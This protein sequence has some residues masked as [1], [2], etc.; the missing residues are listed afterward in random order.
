MRAVTGP[1]QLLLQSS[2][3]SSKVRLAI[4]PIRVVYS[5]QVSIVPS[6]LDEVGEIKYDNGS[7]TLADVRPGMTLWVGSTAG[8]NDLG[9][10]RI[11]KTPTADTFY[12]GEHSDIAWEVDQHLTVIEDYDLWAK[13]V[14]ISGSNILMDFD[15]DYDDQHTDFLP[16][17]VLGSHRVAKLTGA[18][19]DVILGPD[20]GEASYVF[21]STITGYSWSVPGSTGLT[22]S[23]T[24]TPTATFDEAGWYPC[25][26]TVTAANGKSKTGMR[27]VYIWDDDNEPLEVAEISSL[28]EDVQ[29]GG[30]TCQLSF[31]AGFGSDIPERSLAII[32]TESSYDHELQDIG[33]VTHAENILF[34]GRF[35][36]E[37]INRSSGIGKVSVELKS[38]QHW[39]SQ[40]PTYP[41]G[42]E[43]AKNTP[44][45]W[46]SLT[47]LTVDRGL[48]H[49]LEWRSTATEIMDVFLT[50]D[51]RY[52]PEV[53][54]YA[55]NLWEM[56]TQFITQ[57]I[58][59]HIGIDFFGR[60]FAEIDPQIRAD[61][62]DLVEVMTL[63]D[64]DLRDDVSLDKQVHGETSLVDL[65]GMAID[66]F[67]GSPSAFFSLSPGH[68]F[69]TFGQV[70][71]LDRLLLSSQAQCNQI[72]GLYLGWKNSKYRLRV[73]LLAHN[74]MISV[75]PAQYINYT[76]EESDSIREMTFTSRFIPRTRTLSFDN[77]TGIF[78][79]ELELEAETFAE[80]AVA[81][82][83]P[84]GEDISIP[85]LEPLP[86]IPIG[87]PT[88][89][90]DISGSDAPPVV[91]MLDAE[92]G[93]LRTENF[94][95]DANDVVWQFWNTGI[96]SADLPYLR[97]TSLIE[98]STMRSI[99][100]ITP[101]GAC[102]LGVRDKTFRR[103][104]DIIYRA[105]AIGAVWE[106]VLDV[107]WIEE[108]EGANGGF[109]GFGYN[110]N[111]AEEVAFIAA[112]DVG[113]G[114]SP[115]HFYYG[116]P[117]GWI[118]G[119]V[120]PSVQNFYGNITF[121][122]GQ[123]VW[124]MPR[125][126]TRGYYYLFGSDGSYIN[127]YEHSLD[128]GT[129]EHVRAGTSPVI[130]IPA[131]NG[132]GL[133]SDDNGVTDSA[134]DLTSPDILGNNLA[135]SPDGYMMG[136]YNTTAH[137]GRSSDFG[138]TWGAN[139]NLNPGGRYAWKWCGGAT[140]QG[141]WIAARA[142]IW[143]SPDWGGTWEDKDGNMPYLIPLSPTIVKI[144]VPGYH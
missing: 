101:N 10:L 73:T 46:T 33:Q 122:G 105:P 6:S 78:K 26:C 35:S 131:A 132:D 134:I 118:Q 20:T 140:S 109:L 133:F 42:V 12:L 71:I 96:A 25:Y 66:E 58:L 120:P 52:S 113:S 45:E 68:V 60:F 115:R 28:S 128:T 65:S 112:A 91:L 138:F 110:P 143:Y 142:N 2:Y 3:Q 57:Q 74:F 16:V 27:W 72:A 22:G 70:E 29:S 40:L 13:H 137:K 50:N 5:A 44:S 38:H 30:G 77:Q 127:R 11:R 102:Y 49:L 106:K 48:W 67:G 90:G 125:S 139:A 47:K 24:A 103:W 92:K 54:G 85:P 36:H 119:G 87:Y 99:F 82:V 37:V 116:N 129:R 4:L 98:N 89:P 126:G 117:S 23:T 111:K 94:N 83:P 144:L 9:R 135:I 86:S 81:Y 59:G 114:V 69:K 63:T 124:S 123:W 32:F 17:P 53:S 18:T 61:R 136:D 141:R 55:G 43:I 84:S 7:G 104:F 8:A 15:I 107:N 88:Y 41:V 79:I 130:Y 1:E 34:V 97:D 21:D 62:D 80:N 100:F 56:M 39:F 51:T 64:L 31:S 14:K 93:V 108:N 75:F 95:A 76:W 121:G 19:V